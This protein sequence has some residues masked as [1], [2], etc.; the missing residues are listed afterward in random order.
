MAL[1]QFP[2]FDSVIS[3]DKNGLLCWID[4]N[5]YFYEIMAN[6]SMV[7]DDKSI[8]AQLFGEH[9]DYLNFAQAASRLQSKA[10]A[11]LDRLSLVKSI[12]KFIQ[13]YSQ[14]GEMK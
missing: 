12:N 3:E 14:K 8:A 7:N 10:N 6:I 13:I 5:H 1:T 2:W 11:N 9:L 4:T